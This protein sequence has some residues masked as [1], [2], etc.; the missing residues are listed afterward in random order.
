MLDFIVPALA[1][2]GAHSVAFLIYVAMKSGD[3]R[4][5]R[6]LAIQ[7][8]P[9]TIYPLIND[10]HKF[11][12]WNPF[13]QMDPGIKV[14]YSGPAAGPGASY[15]WESKQMGPGSAKITSATAPTNMSLNLEMK[16]F[17]K[18]SN[19]VEYTLKSH[20]SGTDVTWAMSGR[21]PFL[22]KL[23][24]LFINMDTMVGGSFAK[25]LGQLKAMA[26]K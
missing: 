25:G 17:M 16:G 11:N 26:E 5:E 23:M 22:S 21:R 19:I 2:I 1:V 6:S 20:G 4:I 3:F 18:A 8:P 10:L 14:T 7:A 15:D 12:S 13:V 24:G 9:E